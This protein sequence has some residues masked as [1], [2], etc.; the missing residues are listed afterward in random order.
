MVSGNPKAE[1]RARKPKASSA[2][3]SSPAKTPKKT[4]ERKAPKPELRRPRP[5]DEVQADITRTHKSRHARNLKLAYRALQEKKF[6][7]AKKLAA[8]EIPDDQFSDYGNWITAQASYGKAQAA[9]E[10]KKYADAIREAESAVSSQLRIEAKSPYS[11]MLKTVP[12]D[13]GLAEILQGDAHALSQKWGPALDSFESGFQRLTLANALGLVRPDSLLHYGQS[14]SEKETEF[15]QAWMSRFISIYPR[16]SPEMQAVLKAYP[17]ALDR[18]RGTGHS[19]GSQSYKSSDLDQVS[20]EANLAIYMDGKFGAAVKGFRQFIDEFPRSSYRFRA[21]Y[22]LAQAQTQ[23]QDHDKAKASYE[24]LQKDSPLTY[25]GLLAAFASGRDMD[26][27]ITQAM[28]QALERDPW[29]LPQESLRLSRAE[30][31]LAENAHELAAI[32]LKEVKVR[33][34]HSN[35][36][37]MY[38]AALN[39][40]AGTHLNVFNILGELIQRGYDGATTH[41][42]LNLVFP[43]PYFELVRK[44]AT[45]QGL[46]PLLVLSLIKQESAFDPSAGSNV[47]AVGLMQLMPATATDTDSDVARADLVDP[48]TSIR[49][50]TKYLKQ[51]YNRF[52]GNLVLAL[53]GYNAGPNAADRWYRENGQKRGMLEFIETIPYKETREYVSSIMRNYYWYSRKVTPQEPSKPLSYFWSQTASGAIPKTAPLPSLPISTPSISGAPTQ[54]APVATTP[55]PTESASPAAPAEAL[56]ADPNF[57]PSEPVTLPPGA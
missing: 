1:A 39:A 48:D 3:S 27:P 31:F 4:A 13:A 55:A 51:L 8:T 41:A 15:C 52:N 23:E 35:Q 57:S 20:F 9:M 37:L 5:L 53:A 36:F 30:N 17:S 28:P 11:P 44:H 7:A 33:S 47:G 46:D 42:F 26:A 49:V 40:E 24:E 34:E 50:G 14:C 16:S 21:R 43:L 25:Y 6:D 18:P 12:R 22:W 19:K 10:S 56:P 54:T 29:L 2:K 45:N 32:E 38:L